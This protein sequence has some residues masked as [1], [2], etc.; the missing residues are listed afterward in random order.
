MMNEPAASPDERLAEL[1]LKVATYQYTLWEDRLVPLEELRDKHVLSMADL[2]FLAD[3]AIQY[4]PHRLADA[5]QVDM[6]RYNT[7][8]RSTHHAIFDGFTSPDSVKLSQ[9]AELVEAQLA[10]GDVP[11]EI[12]LHL[13]V[14]EDTTLALASHELG[15]VLKGPHRQAHAECLKQ[16]AASHG[17]APLQDLPEQSGA[18]VL[19][20][21]TPVDPV[22][23]GTL[24]V[25]L[26]R[27]G[28]GLYETAAIQCTARRR[29]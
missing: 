26:L 6:F 22:A 2:Q 29:H 27:R 3:Y 14:S 21:P 18:R 5:G 28:L 23:A 10:A 9:L 20:F 11:N 19:S 13:H 1:V 25:D 24:V 17:L 8:D 16:V 12:L 7:P 15:L 4:T